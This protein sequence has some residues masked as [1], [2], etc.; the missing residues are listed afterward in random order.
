[1]YEETVYYKDEKT[2][3]PKELHPDF[4]LPDYN[5]Y[6]E[7]N[8]LTNPKYVETKEYVKKIYEKLK[9]HVIVMTDKDLQDVAACL[10]PQ[11]LL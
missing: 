6:I 2:G 7:Y 9:L 5:L 4:F 1:M 3:E 8:E 10:K 11:L